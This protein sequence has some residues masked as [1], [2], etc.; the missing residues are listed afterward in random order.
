MQTKNIATTEKKVSCLALGTY[1]LRDSTQA[2]A[3]RILNTALDRGITYI[4]TAPCYGKSE[5]LIGNAISGRREEYIL[6]TKC[7]CIVDGCTT[8]H[9]TEFSGR[10]I[11]E[12]LENSLKLLKTDYLD[13]WML[14]GPTL[15]EIGEQTGELIETMLRAKEKGLVHSIGISCKNGAMDDPLFPSGH[16]VSVLKHTSN[17]KTFDIYQ[18]VYG[19]LTRQAENVIHTASIAGSSMICRGSLRKY[20]QNYDSRFEAAE[21]SDLLD[22]GESKNDL[23]IRFTISNPDITAALVG[24][25]NVKH[26]IANITAADKGPLSSE[27]F[28]EVKRRIERSD[29]NTKMNH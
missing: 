18:A 16:T 6:A 13:V 10:H 28:E 29:A 2:T 17:W 12:N 14:H 26:L 27:L 20:S 24:T 23:L 3:D 8:A 4:D 22:P 19:M 15:L 1:E 11:M 9:H 25:Q 5:E 21:L 7:G